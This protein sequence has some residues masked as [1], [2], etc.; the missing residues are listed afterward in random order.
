M[1]VPCLH[2]NTVH[3]HS[4][5]IMLGLDARNVKCRRGGLVCWFLHQ[6]NGS[7]YIYHVSI[8]VINSSNYQKP[9]SKLRIN[10]RF[11]KPDRRQRHLGCSLGY[12]GRRW[13]WRGGHLHA[14]RIAVR[15]AET[16]Y[17]L[18]AVISI[19]P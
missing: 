10:S 3:C 11:G 1:Y 15:W 6:K 5:L 18:R 7:L 8:L 17:A 12:V 2:G 16:A 19:Q 14:L 4:N 13:R 9:C